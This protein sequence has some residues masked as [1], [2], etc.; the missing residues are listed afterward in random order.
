[1]PKRLRETERV[2]WYVQREFQEALG[3]GVR[4]DEA[5]VVTLVVAAVIRMLADEK[6]KG[7]GC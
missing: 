5:V 4:D 6:E 7:R 2:W 1:M 3:R